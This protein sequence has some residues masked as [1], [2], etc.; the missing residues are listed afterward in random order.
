MPLQ[1]VRR[2]YRLQFRRGP[3]Q[4]LGGFSLLSLL[5]CLV[6]DLDNYVL[7]SA[8]AA[9]HAWFNNNVQFRHAFL[10]MVWLSITRRLRPG[11]KFG[12]SRL[13]RLSIGFSCPKRKINIPLVRSSPWIYSWDGCIM[14][15][16]G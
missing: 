2:E 8:S 11:K 6:Q 15:I 13:L 9:F 7:S 4:S 3:W 14:F 16:R 1:D 10:S 5:P 12:F